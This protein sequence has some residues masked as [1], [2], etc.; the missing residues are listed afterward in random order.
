[1][2][3][4]QTEQRWRLPGI[5]V[6]AIG[7]VLCWTTAVSANDLISKAPLDG[8]SDAGDIRTVEI[9][10][11]KSRVL[12]LPEPIETLSIGNA[13]IADVRVIHARQIYLVGQSLGTTNVVLWDAAERVQE[14][15]NIQVTHDL[16]SLKATLHEMLPGE[17]IEVRSTQGR[18]VLSGMVS[19][20]ARL[21][22]ALEVAHSHTGSPDGPQVINMMEVGGAQQVMLDVKVAEVERNLIRRLGIQFDAFGADG[23]FRLGAV[24]GGA[25]FP[26]AVITDP[27]LGDVRVPVLEDGTPI[28]PMVKE[29]ATSPSIDDIGIF[30]SY[31]SGS[32]IFNMILEAAHQEGVARILAEPNLTTQTGQEAHFLAGGEFP[33]PVPQNNGQTTIEYRE[34]GVGLQF[35]PV[36]LSSDAINLKVDVSVSDLGQEAAIALGLGAGVAQ[37]ISVPS[38]TKRRASSTVEL[39]HGETIAIAG[40]VNESLRESVQKFPGLGDL[41]VLGRLFRSEEFLKDQTEVVI[42]VTPRLARPIE[43]EQARLPVGS[44]VAPSDMEFYLLGRRAPDRNSAQDDDGGRS[45]G[46]R[47]QGQ[48]V[49]SSRDG[50]TAG[51]F[52]HGM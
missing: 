12:E 25:E 19:T 6:L 13:D 20:A 36:I 9:P 28:G 21:D 14:I 37:Q 15:I 27:V 40:M 52:G 33:I 17:P 47:A 38:L 30:G 1:M 46:E 41:P 24:Q 48:F 29:F 16:E 44:F 11:N 50:G 43:P 35:L 31:Q 42:F 23:K 49:S 4:Q 32:F 2:H 45:Q 34:F 3:G 18:L 10:L 7:L 8:I 39:A 26:D 51:R 5:G 22:T